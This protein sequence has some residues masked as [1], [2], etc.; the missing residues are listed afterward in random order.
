MR[1]SARTQA[2]SVAHDETRDDE[3][4]LCQRLRQR[5]PKAFRTLSERHLRPVLN[6]AQRMLGNTQEAEDVSQEAFLRLWQHAPDWEPRAKLS[7]WLFRVAHNLAIDRLRQRRPVDT[8]V[9]VATDSARPSRVLDRR[10]TADR[11]RAALALLPDRHRSALL[12]SHYEG[13][14]N[15]EIADILGVSVESV[16]SLSSR[17]RRTLRQ[18]LSPSGDGA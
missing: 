10:R 13:L 18:H 15:P 12:M 16:E 14:S 11:V 6:Y 9:D 2:S 3:A 4:E 1:D 17:A 7:T 8:D 5:D